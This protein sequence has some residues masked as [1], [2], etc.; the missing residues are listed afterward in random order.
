M[1]NCPICHSPL[2]EDLRGHLTV[3]GLTTERLIRVGVLTEDEAAIIDREIR[4][5]RRPM[6]YITRE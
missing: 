2:L 5:Y 3:C 6:P 1:M 4:E